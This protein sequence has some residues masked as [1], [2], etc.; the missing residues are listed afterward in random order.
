LPGTHSDKTPAQNNRIAAPVAPRITSPGTSQTHRSSAGQAH[1][2]ES[3]RKQHANRSHSQ[4]PT[5]R[6]GPA[7]HRQ[8]HGRSPVGTRPKV[9]P[10]RSRP[11]LPVHSKPDRGRAGRPSGGDKADPPARRKTAPAGKPSDRSA[12]VPDTTRH[13]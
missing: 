5:H 13:P 2:G 11:L 6:P 12:R 4:P 1:R 10:R 7:R 8:S 3:A 9:I